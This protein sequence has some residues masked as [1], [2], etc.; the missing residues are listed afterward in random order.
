[1]QS[2][3]QIQKPVAGMIAGQQKFLEE[4]SKGYGDT[5]NPSVAPK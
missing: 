5:N 2:V 3:Q 1:M 4:L